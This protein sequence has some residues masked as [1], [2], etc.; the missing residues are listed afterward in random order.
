MPLCRTE[1]PLSTLTG[2]RQRQQS[3]AHS[4]SRVL[5]GGVLGEDDDEDI[6]DREELLSL[7]LKELREGSGCPRPLG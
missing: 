4:I 2:R 5:V 6:E 1:A 3:V 7:A